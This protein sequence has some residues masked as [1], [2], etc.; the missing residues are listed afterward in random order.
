MTELVQALAD[1][2]RDAIDLLLADDPR[3]NSP[4]RTYDGRAD[5][6]HLLTTLAGLFDEVRPV[7]EWTGEAGAATFVSV[8]TGDQELDGVIEELHGDDGRVASVTLMLR[9]LGRLLGAIEQMGKALE[10]APLPSGASV[11]RRPSTG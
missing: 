8:R 7:R 5:V 3:F 9:P 4:V 11:T 6:L 10:L 2:D 1:G